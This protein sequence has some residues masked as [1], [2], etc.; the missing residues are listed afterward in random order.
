MY[1]GGVI[2]QH[3]MRACVCVCV[4]VC[5]SV[6]VLALS[7][8]RMGGPEIDLFL[9]NLFEFVLGEGDGEMACHFAQ[10]VDERKDYVDV[11]VR[12]RQHCGVPHLHSEI[13]SDTWLESIRD[14]YKHDA[15][16]TWKK[17][18]VCLA[19]RHA[20]NCRLKQMRTPTLTA[21][22]RSPSSMAYCSLSRAL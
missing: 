17:Y 18:S 16:G 3:C 11:H 8:R 6:C 9:Q 14:M 15:N 21:T 20:R 7:S 5:T 22:L 1:C 13:Y 12:V 2:I 19:G 4:C 10:R